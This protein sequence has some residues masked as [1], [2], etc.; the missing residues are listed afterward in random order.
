[1][2]KQNKM[3]YRS[4]ILL[5]FLVIN[6]FILFGI[7]QIISFLNTGADRSKML[8]IGI[9]N[10][11]AYLPKVTWSDTLN[12]GRPMEKH[13]LADIKKDYINAWYVRNVGYQTSD[14]LG[15]LDFY[16]QSARKHII[17]NI[18]YNTN[19]N[20][21]VTSTTLQHDLYLD[22]YSADG[23]L[24]VFEDKGSK[25]YTQV[26]KNDEFIMETTDTFSYKVIMFL[27]DGFWKIRHIVKTQP[28]TTDTD[29]SFTKPL[30]H[31]QIIVDSLPNRIKGI[32]YYPQQTPWDTFGKKFDTSIIEKDFRTLKNMG[33]NTIRI[34][35]P[36]EDFG[37]EYVDATKLERLKSTLD[38]AHQQGLK[39]IIAL[40]DFYGNYAISD[41]TFTHRHM[42]QIVSSLK[43]HEAILA[44]DIKN[45]PDLDFEQRDQ[46]T[47]L[48]WLK[49]MIWQLKQIDPNHY[50]TI[51]WSS[52]AAAKHLNE[53]VDMVSFH[54]Y[55]DLDDFQ[56]QLATL[57]EI[58]KPLVLQEFGIS[59]NRSIWSPLGVSAKQQAEYYETFFKEIHKANLNYLS[60]TLYDFE[61]IPTK[62]VGILPW[63][64]NKQKSFGIIDAT[65]NKK[66]AFEYVKVK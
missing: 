24:V 41:W 17:E 13:T 37:K 2:K 50:V 18:A 27:E 33:L 53:D 28:K 63:R 11:E 22:F 56:N 45:E 5:S 7:G 8:H 64:K 65:G 32:N 21:K 34:F 55:L 58:S 66:P 51:G 26:H 30:E 43:D 40:F 60:W 29:T 57:N 23:Q 62:A 42:E 38:I 20:I 46:T 31:K 44:W 25:S 14:S 52:I 49:E 12:P 9:Q 15:I 61:D 4:I 19:N 3:I 35:V 54:Y 16:T 10:K 47:V 1:M 48:A 59:S 36:Y 39:V 6:G